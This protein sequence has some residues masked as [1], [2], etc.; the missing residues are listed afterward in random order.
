MKKSQEQTMR[1][2]VGDL[3]TIAGFKDYT[4][5]DGPARGM[6]AFDLYNGQGLEL[7]VV[8][9]RGLDIPWMKYKGK[10]VSFNSKTGLRSPAL[11]TEDGVRGF[12]K[13]FFAGLLTTCGLGYAGA[14]VIDNGEALG[15][16]GPYNNTPA[17]QVS[18]QMVYEGD[19]ARIQLTGQVRQSQV[20][21]ENLVLKR[22]LT[23]ETERS[24]LHI[25][26]MVENQAF[27][28]SPL[29]MV[30]HINFGYPM[31]DEG[32]HV[33]SSARHIAPRDENAKGGMERWHTIDAPSADRPEECFFHTQQVDKDAFA[34]LH[35]EK[36]GMA[37]IVRY[38][39]AALPLLCQWKCMR[40]GDY[41]LG[42]EPTTSGVMG[43]VVARED[44]SLITLKPGESRVYRLSLEL[45]D[46]P[47]TIQQL[48]K[49]A[50]SG[51][52]G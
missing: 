36:L 25:E 44:G 38:D 4:F 41:A 10:A 49:Q 9:D 52:K 12:L 35:N 2:R 27:V 40:C 5:N 23:L 39:A 50:V 46:D 24:I 3:N 21:A 26:D 18:A 43:R 6:R 22:K 15:L 13:Q 33:Y 14:A 30:Y 20:F 48:I 17:G 45:T 42:L 28:D 8:A 34:M 19:E 1:Q 51:P 31:L 29:M 47:V 37:A 11:Y 7:T 16:H 32:A